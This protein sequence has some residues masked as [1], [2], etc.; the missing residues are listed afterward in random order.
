MKNLAEFKRRLAPGTKVWLI[1]HLKFSSRND[2]G[3]INYEDSEP[4]PRTVLEIRSKD[5]VFS[6]DAMPNRR[7]YLQFGFAS[8]WKFTEDTASWYDKTNDNSTVKWLTY[9]F[10]A[11]ESNS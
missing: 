5:V 9:T 4:K 3:S 6:V 11:P 10:I 1:F 7:S 2:D 8:G